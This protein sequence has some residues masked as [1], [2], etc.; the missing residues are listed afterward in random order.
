MRKPDGSEGTVEMQTWW[1]EEGEREMADGSK[2][3]F[4]KMFHGG[5]RP[6][7]IMDFGYLLMD[8]AKHL[9]WGDCAGTAGGNEPPVG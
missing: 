3:R 1:Y 2:K 9:D 4:K 8:G 7:P 5:I 6:M